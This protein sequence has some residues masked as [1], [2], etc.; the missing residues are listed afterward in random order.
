MDTSSWSAC[1]CPSSG[2]RRTSLSRQDQWF[3][4]CSIQSYQ[5]CLLLLQ[6]CFICTRQP[7]RWMEKKKKVFFNRVK[8]CFLSGGA[9]SLTPST[10]RVLQESCF[11]CC[12]SLP[13]CTA[14]STSS[15]SCCG[16]LTGCFIRC[17]SWLPA[18]HYITVHE[19]P[20]RIDPPWWTFSGLFSRWP[21]SL[22]LSRS[23]THS[24]TQTYTHES[25]W[26]HLACHYMYFLA[27]FVNVLKESG[28]WFVLFLFPKN[29]TKHEANRNSEALLTSSVTYF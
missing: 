25:L 4:P 20:P 11:C 29:I 27:T 26:N 6:A 18:C 22:S 13:S 14:G 7:S 10:T 2:P 23:L 21:I 3:W 16:S 17:V 24:H 12:A 8:R 5:V 15:P 19:W 9:P 1:A 28:R